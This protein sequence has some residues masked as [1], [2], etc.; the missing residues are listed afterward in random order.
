MLIWNKE[1]TQLLTTCIDNFLS[2]KKDQQSFFV[3]SGSKNIGKSSI[4]QDLIKERLGQFYYHDFLYI[5]DLSEII[6]KKHSLKIETPK[7]KE[8]RYI[9]IDDQTT[10]EDMGVREINHRLQNSPINT[11]K[12]V[13]IENI[14]RMLPAAANA[15]LK[16]LEEPLPHRLIIATVSHQSQLLDTILSRALVIR[17]QE[18][19]TQELLNFAKA[20]NFF[21]DDAEFQKFACSMAMGRPGVLANLHQKLSENSELKN[22][23]QTLVKLLPKEWSIFQKQ[24]ILKKLHDAGSLHVFLDGRISYC[25]HNGL[26]Q[27]SEKRLAIKKMLN[28][29]VNVENVL[30]YAVL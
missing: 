14:E 4:V 6:W 5:R 30:L 15:F 17:F 13:L 16:T 25:A 24:D 3:I 18:L 27:Q 2:N 8:D 20:N 26:T 23:F 19:N 28:S 22:N 12:I 11:C 10:Y 1:S 29:N 7:D 9:A 21:A